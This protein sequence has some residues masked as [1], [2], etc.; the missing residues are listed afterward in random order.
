MSQTHKQY[1]CENRISYQLLVLIIIF[2]TYN[3]K[4]FSNKIKLCDGFL[5]YI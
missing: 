1:I 4:H 3:L 5:K 2:N